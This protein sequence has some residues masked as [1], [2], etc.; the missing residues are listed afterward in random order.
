MME[1]LIHIVLF[2]VLP[3]VRLGIAT[4]SSTF[5]TIAPAHLR[6]IMKV[7]C[8]TLDTLI[9]VAGDRSLLAAAQNGAI[10]PVVPTSSHICRHLQNAR[11]DERCAVVSALVRIDLRSIL[12]ALDGK[13]RSSMYLEA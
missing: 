13:R 1:R 6:S 4:W 8:F 11:I 10:T 2:K 5:P 9:A 7:R 12:G 3:S